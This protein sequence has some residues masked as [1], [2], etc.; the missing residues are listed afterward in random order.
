M[1]EGIRDPD[2]HMLTTDLIT[3][4][5]HTFEQARE[6]LRRAQK[7]L[8]LAEKCIP[9]KHYMTHGCYTQEHIRMSVQEIG[10]VLT[11]METPQ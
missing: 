5:R 6:A 7:A 4:H 8:L 10:D 1:L 9:E 3:I 2:S 11:A